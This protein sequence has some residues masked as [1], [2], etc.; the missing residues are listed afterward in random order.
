MFPYAMRW[1]RRLDSMRL[2][3]E[4]VDC[5]LLVLNHHPREVVIANR[6]STLSYFRVNDP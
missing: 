3:K 2:R 6:G 5:G 1:T 4:S